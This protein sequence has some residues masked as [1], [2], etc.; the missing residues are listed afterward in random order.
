[1][2]AMNEGKKYDAGKPMM[3]LIPPHAELELA[4][5]LTFGAIKYSR[6]GINYNLGTADKVFELCHAG[7][8]EKVIRLK[9]KA[10]ESVS[11]A[12]RN[13]EIQTWDCVSYA[14]TEDPLK[15]GAQENA[16]LAMKN[17][18]SRKTL[19]IEY[20]SVKIEEDGELKI[21]I[22]LLPMSKRGKKTLPQ[23]SE[24][25]I[26]NGI[27]GCGSSDSV[28]EI[29]IVFL[30]QGVSYAAEKKEHRTLTTAMTQENFGDSFAVVATTDWECWEITYKVL[31]ELSLISNPLKPESILGA[32]NWRKVDQLER[33]YMGAAM[34]HLNA[35]R[36]GETLDA[37]SGLHHLAHA[38]C[39][40]AF[41]IENNA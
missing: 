15:L 35:F 36:Q 30:N 14:L 23:D 17:G 20:D 10:Q 6:T 7:I 18:L 38:M 11:R 37:E 2:D 26:L 27:T 34:R 5:V 40:L 22:S 21:P 31:K 3:E 24:I 12:T 41:I 39:C 25:R 32:D 13:E 29:M 16:G 8:V 4:R 9:L 33:R 1:M 28:K 19:T